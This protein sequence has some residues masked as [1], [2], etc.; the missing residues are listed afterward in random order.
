M[1]AANRPARTTTAVPARRRQLLRP[2]RPQRSGWTP[3]LISTSGPPGLNGQPSRYLAAHR[4]AHSRSGHTAKPSRRIATRCRTQPAHPFSRLATRHWIRGPGPTLIVPC[5]I[6][7][8]SPVGLLLKSRSDNAPHCGE[9]PS[10]DQASQALARNHYSDLCVDG[11][12][13]V[14][15]YASG[16]MRQEDVK[17]LI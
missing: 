12:L 16:F 3:R 13:C 6:Y 7:T 11:D 9:A 17:K 10:P 5:C 14:W 8:P 15:V 2:P 1:P 4:A